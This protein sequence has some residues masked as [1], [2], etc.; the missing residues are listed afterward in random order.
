MHRPIFQKS[1]P[2]TLEL[3]TTQ[4]PDLKVSATALPLERL[5]Q[6]KQIH[7]FKLIFNQKRDGQSIKPSHIPKI[8]RQNV[9]ESPK[10]SL[11]TKNW[12]M[13]RPPRHRVFASDGPGEFVKDQLPCSQ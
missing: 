10:V 11:S 1:P 13:D 8:Q 6:V 5:G 9:G 4:R 7:R 12:R 3:L 2:L